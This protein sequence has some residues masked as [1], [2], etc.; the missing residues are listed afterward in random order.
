MPQPAHYSNTPPSP[1]T[2]ATADP[3]STSRAP[4][5]VRNEHDPAAASSTPAHLTSPVNPGTTSEYVSGDDISSYFPSVEEEDVYHPDFIRSHQSHV[6]SPQQSA[7]AGPSHAREPSLSH[8][9]YL[10]NTQRLPPSLA[11]PQPASGT[12][13]PAYPSNAFSPPTYPTVP[14]P[15]TL[16][17]PPLDPSTPLPSTLAS[18]HGSLASLAGALG[19]LATT[20]AQ[21][22]LYTGE[23]LRSMRAGIHGL[24]MQFHDMLTA[25]AVSR[26]SGAGVGSGRAGDTDGVGLGGVP[27]PGVP[28]PWTTYGPRPYGVPGFPHMPGGFTKL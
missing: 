22:A 24:R 28:S 27:I 8:H 18:L 23:E 10:P 9:P 3:L 26:D 21:D 1:P 16:S 19:A 14:D 2:S 11:Q 7:G 4:S 6:H 13:N 17:I 12:L 20:R 15:G 5:S 25:Q